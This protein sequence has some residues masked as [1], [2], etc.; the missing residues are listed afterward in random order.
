MR[1]VHISTLHPPLDVRIFHKECRTLAA[2]GHEVHLLVPDPPAAV[3][4]QVR[5]GALE[6]PT[7][8]LRVVRVWK[9][10]FAAYRRAAALRAD[11]YHFHDTELILVGLL[12]KLHGARVVY[13]VHEDARREA[14]SLNR[15]NPFYCAYRYVGSVVL[16]SLARRCLDAFVCA[17]PA[18]TAQ[19]PTRRAITVRNYPLLEEFN[20]LAASAGPD[21]YDRRANL[22]VYVGVISLIR[23]LREMV[24]AMTL[25]PARLN[26]RLTLAGEVYP[27]SLRDQMLAIAGP[28]RVEFAGWQSRDGVRAR[29]AAARIGLILLHPR[30]EYLE[31]LPV[32]MFEYM[33]AG[34]PIIASDFP[35]LRSIVD[36]TGCGLLVDPMDPPAIA[37]AIRRLLENPVEAR[38]MGRRGK[39]AVEERYN[40]E[41]EA[42]RLVELYRTLEGP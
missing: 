20:G 17:V 5:L 26:A 6:R 38:E 19:F 11:L 4:D 32:K 35:L 24:E 9:R 28:E 36:E 18:I 37:A 8:A 12:L 2:A 30:P 10:L 1:V 7:D 29:L 42:R 15:D 14:V 23:S 33:A 21:D 41:S 3:K 22:V 34:L 25:L 40:W 31:A 16:E 39:C 13:D 27:A